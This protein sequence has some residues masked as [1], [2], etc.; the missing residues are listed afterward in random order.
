MHVG[1]VGRPHGVDGAF[2]VE[3]ASEEESRFDVGAELFV[4]GVPARVEVSRRVGGGRR[5][6][7]LD[8]RA[9]RGAGAQVEAGM[10]ERAADGLAVDQPRRQRRAIVGAGAADCKQLAA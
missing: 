9:E 2:V 10:M 4:D 5:A 3:D 6:I 8:R 7:R 1:R